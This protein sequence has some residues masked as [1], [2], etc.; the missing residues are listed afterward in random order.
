MNDS[1]KTSFEE[2][3]LCDSDL[4]KPLSKVL[5]Y[6][7]EEQ[8]KTIKA[9][10]D[11]KIGTEVQVLKSLDDFSSRLDRF[12]ETSVR[13]SSPQKGRTSSDAAPTKGPKK[14]ILGW[15]K[16][17]YIACGDDGWKFFDSIIDDSKDVVK[18]ILEENGEEIMK[19]KKGEPRKRCEAAMVWSVIKSTEGVK[20]QMYDKYKEYKEYLKTKEEESDK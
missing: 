5:L 3:E 1:V 18:L 9:L 12:T 14:N 6:I 7:V 19:K 17:E 15:I 4:G 13:G 16:D 20:V 8:L 11:N 2:L 10:I